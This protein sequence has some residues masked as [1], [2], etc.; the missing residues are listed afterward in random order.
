MS[1]Q[2]H[3]PWADGPGHSPKGPSSSSGSLTTPASVALAIGPSAWEPLL[4][5]ALRHPSLRVP[6]AKRCL[7]AVELLAALQTSG[8]NVVV[9]SAALPRLELDGVAALRRR[10]CVVIGIVDTG[11]DDGGEQQERTL[12]GWGVEHI[13]TLNRERAGG[14]ATAIA[15]IVRLVAPS[16]SSSPESSPPARQP[17]VGPREFSRAPGRVVAVWGPPGSTGRTTTALALADEAADQG[18]DVLLVDADVDAPSLATLLAVVEPGPGLPVVLRRAAAGRLD[19]PSL[20]E[21]TVAITPALTLLPGAGR[22]GHRAD[23][24]SPACAEMRRIARSAHD[25]VVVDHGGVPLPIDGVGEQASLALLDAL[26]D[27]DEVIVIAGPDA[28]G[29]QRLVQ[30]MEAL[31]EAL[32][33]RDPI[34]ILNGVSG[35]ARSERELRDVVRR[36]TTVAAD[37]L[38]LVPVDHEGHE[39]AVRDGLTLR[40]GSPRSRARAARLEVFAL[41]QLAASAARVRS[42]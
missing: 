8:A 41:L 39:R 16:A 2:A 33:G 19:V 36:H 11:V 5:A 1:A 42:R 4:L 34:V 14:A 35:G 3:E 10:G 6:V 40:E 26:I 23:L 25:L 38:H 22:P 7:D 18:V 24:R 31:D 37:R 17:Q 32:P 30:S 27:A 9:I 29:M 15:G 21:V 13:V 20:S 28:V 12:R